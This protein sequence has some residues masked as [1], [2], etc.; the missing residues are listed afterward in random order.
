MGPRDRYV[1]EPD[2][3]RR[4][5]ARR[6]RDPGRGDAEIRAKARAIEALCREHG[7]ALAAAALQ[8]PLAHPAVAAIIP[9]AIEPAQVDA[10]IAHLSTPIPAALWTPLKA[11]DLLHR[12]APVPTA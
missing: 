8:F 5:A 12:D 3:L 7:V 1:H 11:A 2:Q 10:N 6:T 4:G 9:G